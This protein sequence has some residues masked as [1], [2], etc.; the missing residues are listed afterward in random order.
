MAEKKDYY[1][2][3]GVPRDA[4][5]RTIKRAFLQKAR[6]LHPDVNKDP[7]AEAQFKEVNEAY[8]VLSDDQKR[9]NYDT[10]GDPNGPGGFGSDFV[11]MSDIFG[12]GFGDIFDSFFGGGGGRGG[13]GG[14]TRTRGRDMGVHLVITLEEA[15][16]GCTKTVSYQ[17]LAPCDDCRGTGVGEGGSVGP[18]G[19]CGGS[20]RVY[21]VQNSLF[22]QMR[23]QST[24][25]ECGGSGTA[26][27]CPC[28][29]CQGQGRVPSP[30]RVE[31]EIPAGVHS[32][33]GFTIRGK[34]EA[35]LRGDTSGDLV[36]SVEVAEHE[37][38]ERQGDDLFC[39]VE[40]GS[41]EAVLGT[42]VEVPGILE[43]EVVRVEV[44]A[45]CQHGQQIMVER[46]GMPRQGMRARGRLV[47]VVH[48]VTPTDLTEAQ[49]LQLAA[50][51]A[52]RS[53]DEAPEG[54]EAEGTDAPAAS[55][56]PTEADPATTSWSTPENPFA[57]GARSVR[58][59]AKGRHKGRRK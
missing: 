6:E 33:Q 5:A 25:P 36:A 3:L 15:A 14:E 58:D 54:A 34:G 7:E 26:V 52:E 10:Y 35:G 55:S 17:R 23:T 12:G 22:G 47:A 4:D 2:V 53:A 50:I 8:S 16:A 38:F 1:E 20:G 19:R 46:R 43:G 18:C 48:L 28:E 21:S 51:V 59:A 31:I 49:L 27:S 37:R 41:L 44:P 56:G 9:S 40:V 13:K 24:C 45:G 29:T 32:G 42:T 57:K 11:D 30:E 39:E